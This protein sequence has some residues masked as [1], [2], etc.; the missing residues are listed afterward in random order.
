LPGSK[1]QVAGRNTKKRHNNLVAWWHLADQYA[2][3]AQAKLA[4]A[5]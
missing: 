3:E 2:H 1:L 4:A 5:S